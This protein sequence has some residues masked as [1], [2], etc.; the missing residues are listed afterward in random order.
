MDVLISSE[1][2]YGILVSL[3]QLCKAF[4]SLWDQGIHC[5]LPIKHVGWEGLS[6]VLAVS[7]YSG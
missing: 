6:R 4:P 2:F 7:A 3:G 1:L 5:P